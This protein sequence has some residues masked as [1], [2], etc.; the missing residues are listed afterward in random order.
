MK[1]KKRIVER[2]FG[3]LLSL[4][5][6]VSSFAASTAVTYAATPEIYDCSGSQWLYPGQDAEVSIYLSEP[7]DDVDLMIW[8][9]GSW[10][11]YRDCIKSDIT[12]ESWICAIYENQAPTAMME[13]CFYIYFNGNMGVKYSDRFIIQWTSYRGSKRIYGANRFETARKIADEKRFMDGNGPYKYVVIASGTD[14]ADALG[15]SYL[16]N[17]FDAPILL[18]SKDP[19]VIQDTANEIKTNLRSDGYVFILGGEGAVPKEME[20]E[21]KAV[22]ITGFRR[23]SGKNR[24]ETNLKILEYT[25]YYAEPNQLIICSGKD[26][27]DALSASAT[28]LP[29]MLVGDKLTENQEAYFMENDPYIYIAGGPGAVSQDIEDELLNWFDYKAWRLYGANRYQ[30]SSEIAEYFFPHQPY[31]AVLAYGLN[32]PDGLAGGSLAH[33]A[34]APLLLVE[35]NNYKPAEWYM[36]EHDPRQLF[37]LGGPALISDVTVD[38]ILNRTDLGG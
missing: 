27:A 37:V 34:G 9:N 5:M 38:R 11:K 16:A 32:F 28:G 21:L 19:K 35:N 22:G 13:M 23:F 12:G 3:I 26:F 20:D 17:Y 2:T 31:S 8:K 18:V 36:Y 7:V 24:Y 30:T 10:V 6:L 33:R 1:G 15:G 29:I 25:D 14:F 4:L